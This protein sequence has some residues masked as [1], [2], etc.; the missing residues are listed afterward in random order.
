MKELYTLPLDTLLVS[1][2]IAAQ[3]IE[4]WIEKY[5]HRNAEVMTRG[6]ANTKALPREYRRAFQTAFGG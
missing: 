3:Q 1:F 2:G 6:M 4:S 5:G